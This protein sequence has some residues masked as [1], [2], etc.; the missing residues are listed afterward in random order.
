MDVIDCLRF[1]FCFKKS[2]T[3]LYVSLISF[4]CVS[5]SCFVLGGSSL[6]SILSSVI[7]K[8]CGDKKQ[9]GWLSR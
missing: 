8:N 4:L 5:C 3:L 7:E 2:E 1:L 6:S 9:I